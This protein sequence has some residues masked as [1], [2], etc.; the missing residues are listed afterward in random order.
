MLVI[1]LF[2]RKLTASVYEREKFN[3]NLSC[4]N[5]VSA[6]LRELQNAM[7]LQFT[8]KKHWLNAADNVLNCIHV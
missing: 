2:P 4:H 5:F 8:T 7:V 3:A 6:V 1:E